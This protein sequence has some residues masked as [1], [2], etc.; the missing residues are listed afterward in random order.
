[1]QRE[2]R[3][4]GYYLNFTAKLWRFHAM[5]LYKDNL[6]YALRAASRLRFYAWA[7][8]VWERVVNVAMNEENIMLKQRILTAIV[9]I[10]LL[11]SALFF[12]PINYFYGLTTI[13]T[14]LAAWEWTTLSGITVLWERAV[15]LIWILLSMG[16]VFLHSSFLILGASVCWWVFACCLVIVFPRGSSWW[17]GQ[18]F[19]R[20]VMGIFT[21][22]PC[23]MAINILKTM[24][25][26]G[27]AYLILLLSWVW[28]ADIG[29]YFVGRRFGK[30]LLA[31]HLSPKKSWEGLAG[32]FILLAIILGIEYFLFL[33]LMPIQATLILAGLATVVF[34]MS[35]FGDLF[36][37][38]L[39][40]QA[41]VKDSG[42]ILPGHGGIL[43]RIDSLLSAAPVFVMA[44]MIFNLI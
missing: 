16:F 21:L 11:F 38:M 26:Q 4:Q 32:G 36:E 29:A 10:A 2:A 35:V 18:S 19:V 3:N 8:L 34:V 12:L 40:R 24:G 39:K 33:R 13:V 7:L 1:M 37:S 41:G 6:D 14:L 5:L 20:A 9:L 30:T 43:D 44:L 27:L 15:Y 25:Y 28:A 42:S 31:P 23:W 22:L 17:G